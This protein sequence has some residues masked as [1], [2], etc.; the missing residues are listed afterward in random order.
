MQINADDMH[1]V[2]TVCRRLWWLHTDSTGNVNVCKLMLMTCMK[3][4]S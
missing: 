2:V 4:D 1:E 3:V